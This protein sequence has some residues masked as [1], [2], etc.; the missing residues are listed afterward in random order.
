MQLLSSISVAKKLSIAPIVLGLILIIITVIGISA[1]NG[2]A[3]RM[4]QITFDLAPDTE[5][6]A[7]IT[8]SLYRLRLT[9]KNYVKTG[10]DK[11]VSQFQTQSKNWQAALDKAF[12]EIQN[13]QRVAMLNEIKSNK[14]TYVSTFNNIVVSNQQKRNKAVTETLNA[15]GP[16]IERGLTKIMQSANDDGDI[17]A[18]FLAGTAIRSLLLGR[19]YV[20]KF[21]VENQ[22]SQVDR[23]NQELTDTTKQID[24]LL[25][26]LQNPTRR[27]YATEAKADII[28]YT[29]IANNVSTYIST[30]NA[31]IKTLDTIGPQVANQLDELRASIAE[32]MSAASDAANESQQTS[33][34]LLLTVALIAIIFGLTIAYIISRA[35]ISSLDSMNKVFADIAQGEGDLTKRIPVAG[36]DELSQLASSFNLFAEKIQKTVIEVSNSTE[37]LQ[38]ASDA[39]T[40]KAKE[41]QNEVSQQQS[42]AQLA[43]AAM[44]E[45]SASASEVSSSA[46]QAND[47]SS[48]ALSTASTGR[49][50]VINAVSSMSALSTQLTDSSGII[51]NLRKDS[52]Q[53]GTVLDVIRSIA[54][55]TNL[56]AL[57]AAIEAARAGEQGR[58]FAVVADEV[59]SLASRTQESTE[60]IQTIIQTL[61]Q[62]SESAF[63]AMTES[64]ASA[65]S[66]A[67]LVQSAEQS[68]GQIA[69]FMD[70]INN[71]IAHISD[72]AGQQATVSDEVSQ[73]VNAVS[74]ISAAT[75]GQ[76][77]ETCLSAEELSILGDDLAKSVSQFKIS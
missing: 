18:A 38:S 31:G 36:Q 56:L 50:V 70:E 48:S 16:E 17:H 65:E 24:T 40:T 2:L 59:R 64:C 73:N 51:E 12:L 20:S 32:S 76:T 55:Q 9:V 8:S 47:L 41:T 14:D 11:W 53:I 43:A 44:T 61:Q 74:E 69:E 75:Y 5:L 57:N 45:M 66:T 39:L 62:R 28:S 46:N 21:L 68:L 25:E 22:P 60:E 67:E 33:S 7:D 27:T 26:S 29:N 54:E 19:L 52:E 35:I 49:E 10:D 34:T 37:Q 42:Q 58:G 72:A 15:R 63:K 13:P 23:F 4:H 3:S 30:R 1:L 77:E 6:A 71:S